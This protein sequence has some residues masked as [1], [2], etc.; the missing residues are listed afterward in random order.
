[1]IGLPGKEYNRCIELRPHR[2]GVS[3]GRRAGRLAMRLRHLRGL[4]QRCASR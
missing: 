3:R 4:R 2:A 1:M